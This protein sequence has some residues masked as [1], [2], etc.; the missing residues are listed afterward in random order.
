MSSYIHQIKSVSNEIRM[1]FFVFILYSVIQVVKKRTRSTHIH[2]LR[3][4]AT[5]P[6]Y[7]THFHA[8]EPTTTTT[9]ENF[10]SNKT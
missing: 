8:H 5:A 7:P 4:T 6:R 2:R 1:L 3:H 10:G 9:F